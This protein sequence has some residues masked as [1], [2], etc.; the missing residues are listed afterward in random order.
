M[1]TLMLAALLLPAVCALASN[2]DKGKAT[3]QGRCAT[4]H[5]KDGK[6]SP[7]MA[8]MFNV[9]PE[10]LDLTL[11]AA[12]LKAE[13]VEKSIAAGKGKMPGFKQ[14]LS[15]AEIKD[16]AAYIESLAPAKAPAKREGCQEN[17]EGCR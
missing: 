3:Y 5:G 1:R 7:S 17:G 10:K 14:K 11:A 16:V 4:C 9:K 13:E 8:R 15:E 2:A 12:T 6:G